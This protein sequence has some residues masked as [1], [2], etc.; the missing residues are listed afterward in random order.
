M[1][2]G[3]SSG[4]RETQHQSRYLRRLAWDSTVLWESDFPAHHDVESLADGRLLTLSSATRVIDDGGVSRRI[5][6]EQIVLAGA[7]GKLQEAYSLFDAFAATPGIAPAGLDRRTVPMDGTH[8]LDAF[9]ANSVEWIDLP[10]FAGQHPLYQ[11]GNV[12]VSMRHQNRIAVLDRVAKRLLWVW[13]DGVLDGQHSARMLANGNILVFDNALRTRRSRVL[14]V[15]PRTNQ[16]VTEFSGDE[17]FYFY[18]LGGG[19]SQRLPN[20]NTLVTETSKGHLFEVTPRGDLVWRFVNP[21]QDPQS[22]RRATI[23]ASK[24]L[25]ATYVVPILAKNAVESAQNVLA[26]DVR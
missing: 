6:D 9:H 18:T 3:A 17:S 25:P 21:V 24:W 7:D 2:V 13:G 14:E 26:G 19:A 11:T 10:Q 4:A 12:L 5:I 22:P 8:A 15:D 1:V 20:G 16:V 23:H